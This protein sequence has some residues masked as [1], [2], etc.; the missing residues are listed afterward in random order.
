MGRVKS[1]SGCFPGE[2]LAPMLHGKLAGL[3]HVGLDEWLV[4]TDYQHEHEHEH[5]GEGRRGPVLV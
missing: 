4:R 1:G 2:L 5:E 3:C